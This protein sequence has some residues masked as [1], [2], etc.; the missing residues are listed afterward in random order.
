MEELIDILH[1]EG[2]TLVLKSSDGTIHRFTQ[3]GVKDLLALVTEQPEVLKGALI[4]DKAVG[5]AAAA[6]MTVGGV[7]QVYADVMSQPALA[8]LEQQGVMASYTTPVDHII[9]RTGTDWC[10]MEKLSRD[11]DDPATIITAI[12]GFFNQIGK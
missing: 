6:C 11:I 8:L 12:K 4:A 1:S 7:K 3:R 10:P 9:N 5:K 2:L